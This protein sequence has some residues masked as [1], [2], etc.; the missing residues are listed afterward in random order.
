[1]GNAEGQNPRPSFWVTLP[2]LITAI[3]ALLTAVGG[4]IGGLYAAG[5]IA[6]RERP[7][8][9]LTTTG[10]T[11][12]GPTSTAPTTTGPPTTELTVGS[13]G[14]DVLR[15][16]ERLDELGFTVG[17]VDSVFTDQTGRAVFAFGTCWGLPTP[18]TRA[19]SQVLTALS[20]PDVRVGTD[21][22]D[23]WNGTEGDDIYFGK[24]GNDTL[25]GMGG[26][27]KI[28]A[29]DGP[30]VVTGGPGSDR[31]YGGAGDDRLFGDTG[32][33]TLVGFKGSDQRDGG[34]GLDACPADTDD[35]PPSSCE[36]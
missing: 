28:C 27:D 10:P 18:S 3:A 23:N 5:I 12:S 4:L 32:D 17:G 34:D 26:N 11:T 6:P 9:G 7:I 19:D 15:L 16:E 35:A 1:M 36:R 13:T 20:D 8:T 33:D 31:L 24:D 22:N 2:G 14:E 30:D 25:D 29:G 21:Q